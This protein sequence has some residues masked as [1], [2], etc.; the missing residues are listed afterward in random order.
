MIR[1]AT[2]ADLPRLNDGAQEFYA[3]SRFLS[4]F[5]LK[6]FCSVWE[7]WI[8]NGIGTIFLLDDGEKIQGALGGLL[9]PDAY[10][11]S[12]VATE[13]FWFVREDSR[14]KGLELYRAFEGWAKEKQADQIRMVHLLDSMPEKLE[15]VYKRLGFVPAETH[16]VKEIT[17]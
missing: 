6:R 11:P 15:I 1:T 16:Y 14:G 5:D 3:S 17:R 8:G 4:G 12:L 13:M 9:Y 2:K 10:S 7:S